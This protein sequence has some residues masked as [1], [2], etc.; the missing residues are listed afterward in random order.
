MKKVWILL[1]LILLI[2]NLT[3]CN[4]SLHKVSCLH[5]ERVNLLEQYDCIA[6]YTEYENLSNENSIP[7]DE[8]SVKAFQNG[9][10]LSPIV[11]TGDKVNGFSQCDVEVQA[12]TKAKIVW[13]FQL[14]D[15]SK[16]SV[17]MTGR[18]KLVLDL[19]NKH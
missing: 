7:A 13:Y 16:V 3:G 15:E 11:P 18:D 8:V 6:L 1:C 12:K 4:E 5:Y 9:V 10:E 19:K 2:V 17:E 14:D